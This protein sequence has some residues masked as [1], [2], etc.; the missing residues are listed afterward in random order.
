MAGISWWSFLADQKNPGQ[1]D[2]RSNLISCLIQQEA[3]WDHNDR[4]NL[5]L[6]SIERLA[7][8]PRASFNI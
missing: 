6:S 5:R 2:Q 8:D 1:L 7:N 4:I 3:M